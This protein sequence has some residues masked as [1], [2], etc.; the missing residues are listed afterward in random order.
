MSVDPQPPDHARSLTR[1]ALFGKFGV[2]NIGNECTLAAL[3]H[4]I[5]KDRPERDVFCVCSDPVDMSARHKIRGVRIEAVVHRPGAQHSL[6]RLILVRLPKEIRGWLTAIRALR[7]TRA[8]LMTGTGML[9][10]SGESLLGFPYEI[11]KWVCAARYCG[12]EV[13]FVAVG[14][15]PMRRRL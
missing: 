8:L 4:R 13:R 3:L 9:T 15:G 14:V 2:Q 10:D 5:R 12:C 1:V 7:G 11:F 6:F